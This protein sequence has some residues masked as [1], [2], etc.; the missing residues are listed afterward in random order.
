M[1]S[2]ASTWL[3][4]G[5]GNPGKKYAFNRHNIG[6]MALDF[7]ARSLKSENWKNSFQSE[8]LKLDWAG[9]TVF[10]QKPQTFMNLSGQAVVELMQ[11]YKIS[12]ENLIVLHDEIDLPCQKLK[13]QKN[14]GAGG[15]NGLKDIHQKLGT[16]DYIRF[17]MGVGKPL[18]PGQAIVDYVLQNFSDDEMTAIPA[19]IEITLDAVETLL[20]DGLQKAS[21]KYNQTGE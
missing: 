14:R 7:L 6:F 19:F 1:P 4:V 10:L 5:L 17:R 11:F 18:H 9:Q 16:A 20:K 8:Y 15:H 13:I 12:P 21:T 2:G 3:V